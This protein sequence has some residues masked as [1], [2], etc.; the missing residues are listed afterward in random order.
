MDYVDLYLIHFPIA[1]QYVPIEERYPPEWVHD[2]ASKFPKME[3]VDVPLSET[4]AAMEAAANKGLARNIGV[5]NVTSGAL[6]DLMC[7]ASIVPA[8]L[9]VEMSPYC[10]QNQLLRYACKRASTLRHSV[11]LGR[12]RTWRWVRA[13]D[14]AC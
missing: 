9:H 6:R 7:G 4:W 12:H 13:R 5:C 1:M 11:A 3:L 10:Q 14:R 8:V 2:P